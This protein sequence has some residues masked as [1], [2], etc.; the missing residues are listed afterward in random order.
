MAWDAWS[1]GPRE[2]VQEHRKRRLR[3]DTDVARQQFNTDQWL[4][5]EEPNP[6]PIREADAAI[7]RVRGLW[8]DGGGEPTARGDGI[9]APLAEPAKVN[10]PKPR[11]EDFDSWGEFYTAKNEYEREYEGREKGGLGLAF[12]R[13]TSGEQFWNDVSGNKIDIGSLPEPLRTVVDVVG[14]P[15]TLLT[16]AAGGPLAAG[17]KGAGVGGRVAAGLVEPVTKGG[18]LGRLAGESAVGLGADVGSRVVSRQAQKAGL[19]QPLVVAAG[20]VGGL[21]AGGG[22]F[23][24][25]KRA[26]F[27]VPEIRAAMADDKLRKQEGFATLRHGDI[28]ERPDLFQGR[29]ADPGKTFS[30]RRVT[31][32]TRDWDPLKLEPGLVALDTSTGEHVVLRGHHR[33]EAMKRKAA[34]GEMGE[35]GTW[36]VIEADLTDPSAIPPLRM[37]AKASNY[38]TA[39]TNIREDVGFTRDILAETEPDQAVQSI[40]REMR[41]GDQYAQDLVMLSTLPDDLIDRLVDAGGSYQN[42]AEIA[43][44]ARIHNLDDAAIRD[45]A[46][47]YAPWGKNPG[48]TR[49]ALRETLDETSEIVAR[50]R[51]RNAVA[52]Q[53]SMFD[54]D[55]VGSGESILQHVN[56]LVDVKRSIAS[57][58]RDLQSAIRT[59]D[60]LGEGA[61][62]GVRGAIQTVRETAERRLGELENDATAARTRIESAASGRPA[63]IDAGGVRA[64]EGELAPGSRAGEARGDDLVGDVAGAPPPAG[65]ELRGIAGDAG[66]LTQP[67]T[68]EL[69]TPAVGMRG[70]DVAAGRTTPV[71]PLPGFGAP[72]R[73]PETLDPPPGSGRGGT[74]PLEANPREPFDV[75]KAASR[76]R[77]VAKETARGGNKLR[78]AMGRLKPDDVQ[79][80][81]AARQFEEAGETVS[82]YMSLRMAKERAAMRRAGLELRPEDGANYLY[83]NGER[84]G[85]A[86]DIIEQTSESGR[87]AFA[88]LTDDQ[89]AAID[90]VAETNRQIDDTMGIHGAQ[91][92]HD[93]DIE[94]TY[95]GRRVTSRTIETAG[96]EK[97]IEAASGGSPSR[98]V[99]AT[100]TKSRYYQSVEDAQKAGYDIDDPWVARALRSRAKL[101]DAQ[102][103]LLAKNVKPLA[104]KKPGSTF[105]LEQVNHPAF[106]GNWFD[107]RVADR[108]TKA[109]EPPP[110]GVLEKFSGAINRVLT[111]LRATGDASATLQQGLR[112]WLSDP[113]AASEYWARVGASLADDEIYEN[114]ILRFDERAAAQGTTLEDLVGWGMRFTDELSI[115]DYFFSG[116]LLNTLEDAKIGKPLA[117]TFKKSNQ[118]FGRL[119]NAYRI[120]SALGQHARQ[121]DAGF[122]GAEMDDMMRSAMAGVNRTYGWTRSKPTDFEKAAVFAPRYFRASMET[123]AKAVEGTVKLGHASPEAAIARNHMALLLTEGAAAVWL[124]NEARGYETNFD[125][126]DPNFLRLRNV[127]GLDVSPFGTYGTLFRAIATVA[128]GSPGDFA[129]GGPIK[130][131]AEA[132]ERVAWGK[133]SPAMKLIYEPFIKKQTYLGEPIDVLGDPLGALRYQAQSS[134]PF[135]A[136]NLIEEGPLAGAVGATGISSTPVTAAEKRDLARTG[137]RGGITV[138]GLGHIETTGRGST[139]VAQEMFDKPYDELS[140]TE[141][142]I[143]NE[144]PRVSGHQEDVDRQSLEKDDDFAIS[145][146]LRLDAERRMEANAKFLEDGRDEAGNLFTGDDYRA[147][148][149]ELQDT[150]RG[151]RDQIGFGGGD[152]EVNGWFDLF[153]EAEMAN[154]QPDW[155]KLEVLQAQYRAEHPEIDKKLDLI[156]YTNDDA[157]LRRYRKAQEQ[158]REYYAIPAYIGMTLEES[159]RVTEITQLANNL[160]ATGRA[161]NRDHAMRL[162]GDPEGARLAKAANPNPE[163]A[164]YRR[165]NPE[166]AL[167]Y[168]GL[169]EDFADAPVVPSGASV[170]SPRR[171]SRRGR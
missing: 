124:I 30:E 149:Q 142:S 6:D 9:R 123:L 157:T 164:R 51:E 2:I 8:G 76:E 24:A 101:M 47:W 151:A 139:G 167:F 170:R 162:I 102:D 141:K 42:L 119:L 73:P 45:L 28:Q 100:R 35:T 12:R 78:S 10:P 27:T 55:G 116:K 143:V 62:E 153:T 74:R 75:F 1:F 165:E 33:L 52:G 117:F 41:V 92:R 129:D 26:G 71:E 29:D 34:Q 96:G 22:T 70:A 58:K 148:Y 38:T 68:P 14:A 86:D 99:G 127:A 79:V 98:K 137:D 108:L 112:M 103:A 13:L 87:A 168:N 130:E 133:L 36:E 94:G 105:G 111:P 95:W 4:I 67:G 91:I 37:L 85:F 80:D 11:K 145:T 72:P 171:P 65:R 107:K 166:F 154:G 19:P 128:A 120:H 93:E 110:G 160:V 109:L 89:K 90:V 69:S 144:D 16:A 159:A 121:L 49:G 3:N 39:K 63:D 152:P 44:A 155:D 32:I 140:G 64:G 161:A 138:P 82:H 118:H 132:M 146:A 122:Q 136:Q 84:L 169:T 77:I 126:R 163:R 59:M 147:A 23:M 57:Q 135:T 81:A 115:D 156:M 88:R 83:A 131:R 158:A 61:D 18:F 17:L 54:V 60:T 53:G 125:P 106:S 48:I 15:S 21:A 66:E 46:G 56:E 104:V 114:M 97:V 5:K 20:L 134:L 50:A 150:M 25:L 40:R 7:D 31:E 113:K 43:R